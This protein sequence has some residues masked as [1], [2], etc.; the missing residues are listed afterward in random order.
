MVS[1]AVTGVR[2]TDALLVGVVG[3]RRYAGWGRWYEGI[4]CRRV[5]LWEAD[6]QAATE[7]ALPGETTMVP[8]SLTTPLTV[9][10]Q[11]SGSLVRPRTMR[12]P[13][14]TGVGPAGTASR[15]RRQRLDRRLASRPMGDTGTCWSPTSTRF[16]FQLRPPP[17]R[18]NIEVRRHAAID[19]LP[20]EAFSPHPR[21]PA[22]P[23]ANRPGGA[24]AWQALRPGGW[25]VMSF[26]PHP[27]TRCL[28]H[29]R[30]G[31]RRPVRAAYERWGSG[32]RRGVPGEWAAPLSRLA[33]GLPISPERRA[34][35]VLRCCQPRWSAPTWRRY[36]RRLSLLD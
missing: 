18:A 36:V 30:P 1:H 26:D 31:G 29:G 15:S 16:L 10:A 7:A 34:R 21:T 19:P 13:L 12:F 2:M 25:L 35:R 9:G 27:L 14:A 5:R 20:T 33:L 23:R 6:R 24:R 3:F 32:S 28:P 22:P 17:A 8:T 4:G 11:R